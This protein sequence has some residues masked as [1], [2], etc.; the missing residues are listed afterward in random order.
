MKVSVIIACYNAEKYLAEAIYSAANQSLSASDYEIIAVN[1]GSTDETLSILKAYSKEYSNIKVL[2]KENGGPSSARNLGLK[3]AE[4]EY[5]YFFDADD[6]MEYDSLECLY[7]RAKE[8]NADMVIARYDIFS[9]TKKSPVT[10]INEMVQQDTIDKYDTR[11]LWTFALWN[12]LFKKSVIDENDITFPPVSNAEDGVFVFR[13]TCKTKKITGLDKIILHYRK[14]YN[15]VADSITTAVS[16]KSIVGYMTAHEI[17]YK[18]ITDGMLCDYP[19]LKSIDDIEKNLKL[20]LY[21]NEFYKKLVHLAINQF[22]AKT[23][24]LDEEC[25][26]IVTDSIKNYCSKMSPITLSELQNK[27]PEV[28]LY[29]L[30][31]SK[32]EL[33]S[34]GYITAVLYGN[35]CVFIECLRSIVNQNLIGIKIVLNDSAKDIVKNAGLLYD[36]I[37]FINADSEAELFSTA[38]EN[39]DTDI[40]VFCDSKFIYAN[41]AFRVANRRFMKEKYDFLTGAVYIDSCFT[42]VPIDA[43]SR[44]IEEYQTGLQTNGITAFDNLLANKFFSTDF[45]KKIN[46]DITDKRITELC[47]RKGYCAKTLNKQLT[48]KGSENEFIDYLG[49]DAKKLYSDITNNSTSTLMPGK[50]IDSSIKNQVCIIVKKDNLQ[51]NGK[52]LR[53]K[54]NAKAKVFEI[55][56]AADLSKSSISKA[57]ENSSVVVSEM[58]L[59]HLSTYT[60]KKGQ[61]FILCFDT[62]EL[63][64]LSAL[65]PEPSFEKYDMIT[66]T[67]SC[68]IPV[69]ADKLSLEEKV[70]SATGSVKSDALLSSDTNIIKKNKILK[71]KEV[72]LCISGSKKISTNG[73]DFDSLSS[74]LNA[75]QIV[76]TNYKLDREYPNIITMPKYSVREL[77]LV[78]DML[79]CDYSPAVFEC[80]LL[81]KPIVFFCPDMNIN[82]VGYCLHYP[83]DV[84]SYLIRT[85]EELNAFVADKTK[86]I[87]HHAQHSFAKKYM[88]SCDGKSAD[89][90]AKIIND[91][92]EVK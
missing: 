77:M 65:K 39:A 79:I 75:D 54:L 49:S 59:P 81:N 2:N 41:N 80:S 18:T 34:H 66:V 48:F 32:K 76:I 88:S 1:D 12:K 56:S 26:K 63:F 78:S 83:E 19:D 71:G 22:Y 14:A 87:V 50:D 60:P 89:R 73:I 35:D 40:I 5:I 30:G 91:Y 29:N 86:H 61:R 90:I 16:K 46:A 74:S 36:N 3:E 68:I 7:N 28:P 57:I 92:T 17:I 23:L 43:S 20:S 85:Q 13:Y 38:L 42:S 15:G 62:A 25:I 8:Q 6:I 70:F 24:F 53:R 69:C 82:N 11:I 44:V 37:E 31:S 45:L 58:A 27:H 4:G 84:P 67:D 10:N 52:I 55:E 47:Y 21:I 64:D 9:K 72:I 33:L 51:N